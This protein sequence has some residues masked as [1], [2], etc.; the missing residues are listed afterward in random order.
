MDRITIKG[1]TI[2]P[3]PRIFLFTNEENPLE[4]TDLVAREAYK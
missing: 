4:A 1:K 2:V 3:K